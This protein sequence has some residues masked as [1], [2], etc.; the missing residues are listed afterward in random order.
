MERPQVLLVDAFADEPTG[1][2]QVAVIPNSSLSEGQRRAIGSELSTSGVVTHEDGQ[3]QYTDCDGTQAII[4]AAVAGYAA[5]TNR[6]LI[7]PS[8][9]DFQA[10]EH[11]DPAAPFLIDIT[12]DGRVSMELPTQTFESLSAETSEIAAAIGVD[13]ATLEDVGADLPAAKTAGF[14]GTVLVPVNFLEHISGAAPDPQ[15]L[16]SLLEAEGASRLIAFTFDTLE[17]HA[18]VHA[19]IFDPDAV[20]NERA[21]S[22]VGIGACAAHL[23]AQSMFDGDRD[24]IDVEVGR[25]LDRPGTIRTTISSEPTVSGTAL[26]VLD[27]TLGIP[28]DDDGDDIIEV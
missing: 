26:T 13:V 24:E 10:G 28:E 12:E 15:L 18:D 11:F 1:G 14:G 8:S 19:R 5:L 27:A 3:L 23:A 7:K 16:R 25:F 2:R 9:H 17:R 6:G 21:A 22:G 20:G 4:T